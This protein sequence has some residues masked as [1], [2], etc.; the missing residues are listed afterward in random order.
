MINRILARSRYLILIP[1]FGALLAAVVTFIYGG[2]AVFVATYQSFAHGDFSPMGAKH[3]ALAFIEMIDLFLLGTVLYI[4]VLGLYDLFIDDTLPMPHWL[5]ITDLE[6]LKEKLLGVIVVLLT[7]TFLGFVVTWDGT[8]TIMAL[9]IAVGAVL[10]GLGLL[11]NFAPR[12]H[13]NGSPGS[14]SPTPDAIAPDHETE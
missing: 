1:V 4:V 8:N 12:W 9:G 13:R 11:Y 2:V 10:V 6:A 5:L 14:T 3:V 7:V